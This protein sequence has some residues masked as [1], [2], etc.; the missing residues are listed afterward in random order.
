MKHIICHP[1]VGVGV[2]LE[3]A[4]GC[5]Q[6]GAVG[7]GGERVGAGLVAACKVYHIY[8]ASRTSYLIA[9]QLDADVVVRARPSDVGCVDGDLRSTQERTVD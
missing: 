9:V 1:L 3:G 7:V 6:G 5:L 4:G 2:E 8:P